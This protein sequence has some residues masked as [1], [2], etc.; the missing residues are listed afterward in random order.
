MGH[1]RSFP[2]L[3]KM[4][5]MVCNL[6]LLALLLALTLKAI[7]RLSTGCPLI[8][9]L[10]PHICG[11]DTMAGQRCAANSWRLFSIMR[12]LLLN[13]W[14]M[15]GNL[16]LGGGILMKGLINGCHKPLKWTLPLVF[17]TPDSLKNKCW[18]AA[19]AEPA[20][21]TFNASSSSSPFS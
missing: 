9:W 2:S 6:H 12:L 20:S 19:A 16:L 11:L 4:E 21:S 5:S 7:S 17:S 15:G 8:R 1:N 18:D 10:R 14:V 3:R 13:Q